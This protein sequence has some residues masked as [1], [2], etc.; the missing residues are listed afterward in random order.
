MTVLVTVERY[1]LLTG[2]TDTASARVEQAL[3]DATGLLADALG[4]PSVLY[5]THTESLHLYA[6][7]VTGVAMAFP[8]VVPV[9]SE[10]NGL[11]V[12]D[13]VVYGASP[14]SVPGSFEAFG[15]PPT[16]ATLTYTAGWKSDGTGRAATPAGVESDV[17]WAAYRLL[18]PTDQVSVPVGATSVRLGD[19]SITYATPRQPGVASVAWSRPTLAWRRRSP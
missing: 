11:T 6:H 12:Q 14:D 15:A 4:R 16:A 2:D 19:A 17:V 13:D 3:T 1:Q 8:N 9:H 5:G 7:P 10:A 18:R